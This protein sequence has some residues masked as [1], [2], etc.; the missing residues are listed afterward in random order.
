MSRIF[1]LTLSLVF[2]TLLATAQDQIENTAGISFTVDGISTKNW[3]NPPVPSL[4]WQNVRVADDGMFA[5]VSLSSGQTSDYLVLSN[6]NFNIPPTYS[7][8]QI[9]IKV[10]GNSSVANS[11]TIPYLQL[12]N[13]SGRGYIAIPGSNAKSG[14]VRFETANKSSTQ[15]YGSSCSQFCYWHTLLTPS[16]VNNP[17]FGLVVQF[18]NSDASTSV[19]NIDYISITLVLGQEGALPVNFIGFTGKK[20]AT[21]TQLSWNVSEEKSV[22]FYNVEK[23]SDGVLFNNI[24]MVRATGDNNYSFTDVQSSQELTFYRIKNIDMDERF[25]YSTVLSFKN[26]NAALLFKVFP[27]IVRNN[28]TVQHPAIKSGSRITLCASD[29][30][31][32]RSFVPSAGSIQTQVDLGSQRSGIY[33]VRFDNGEGKIE[34]VKVVKQ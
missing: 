2:F 22:K 28:F 5:G 23:S 25:K 10:Y 16:D 27:T 18:L 26:G 6:F 30:R 31:L 20:T 17:R 9:I 13:T 32:I 3:D 34:T 4:I 19:A 14:F 21:G 29:G 24:G 7:I 1:T 15:T 33:I 8:A 12:I 11:I